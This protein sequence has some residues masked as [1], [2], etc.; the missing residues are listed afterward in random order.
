MLLFFEFEDIKVG[1]V[2]E[3]SLIN[4]YKCFELK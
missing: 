3:E 1:E 2:D 4:F